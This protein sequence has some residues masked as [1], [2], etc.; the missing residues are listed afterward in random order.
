MNKD[1]E[2]HKLIS[3]LIR[4]YKFIMIAF[5]IPM[6][7]G[8]IN[9]LFVGDEA[10]SANWVVIWISCFVIL[11]MALKIVLLKKALK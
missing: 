9:Q 6:I 4:R 3:K 10:H 2:A 7:D 11:M 1:V 5:S 8:I